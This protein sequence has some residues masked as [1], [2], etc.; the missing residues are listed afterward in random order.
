MLW[1]MEKTPFVSSSRDL[2]RSLEMQTKCKEMQTKCNLSQQEVWHNSSQGHS[3]PHPSYWAVNSETPPGSARPRCLGRELPP[4]LGVL[5]SLSLS[6]ASLLGCDPAQLEGER[7]GVGQSLALS[8]EG[9]SLLSKAAMSWGKDL[10]CSLTAA[11]WV[12]TNV[13]CYLPPQIYKSVLSLLDCLS[14]K[15]PW[16]GWCTVSCHF[17][18]ARFSYLGLKCVLTKSISVCFLNV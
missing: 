2:K 11:S 9:A 15:R 17:P 4:A 14:Q 8:W 5:G 12:G 3:L 16:K 13:L 1:D 7:A 10:T 18:H 6:P